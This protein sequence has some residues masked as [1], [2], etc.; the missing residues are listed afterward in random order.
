[1]KRTDRKFL[2]MLTPSSNTL[3]EP[4]C[5]QMLAGV[6]EVTPHFGRFR[7]TEISL[8]TQALGQF[9]NAPM[10]TASQLLADAKC[11]AICWNG[12]SAGWLGFDSDRQLCADIKAATGI[13]ACS[14]VLA[15]EEI[16]RKTGVHRFG[17]VTPYIDDIQN[18]IIK[19]F[20]KEGFE[21]V[22]ERHAGIKVNFDFS[23]IE[24]ATVQN[25]IR[26]VANAKPDAILVFCTNVDGASLAES[27]EREI[28]IP[29]Y[30]TIATAVWASLRVAGVDPKRVKGW[31]RLFREIG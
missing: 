17:L 9:T 30:D 25:M 7:V 19:N 15:I 18:A 2:G 16:F 31:G 21:C 23:E 26:D 6:P 5:A 14:S 12:T 28:G 3:L 10:I 22:A 20:S 13:E 27:V 29:I 1:M 24:P 11:H 4:V 8:G